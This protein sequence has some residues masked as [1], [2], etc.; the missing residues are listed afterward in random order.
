M[1]SALFPGPVDFDRWRNITGGPY[2]LTTADGK[3]EVEANTAC[4]ASQHSV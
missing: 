1:Y 2:G 3:A 4:S